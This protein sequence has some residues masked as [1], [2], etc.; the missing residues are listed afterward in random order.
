MG[1]PWIDGCS[2]K[3]CSATLVDHVIS[4]KLPRYRSRIL[5][6]LHKSL[7][8]PDTNLRDK[9]ARKLKTR[10]YKRS[11][12]NSGGTVHTGCRSR[13]RPSRC[14]D[15]APLWWS[16][17]R[18][19]WDSLSMPDLEPSYPSENAIYAWSIDQKNW[20]DIRKK[21]RFPHLEKTI[22]RLPVKKRLCSLR[23]SYSKLNKIQVWIQFYR[24]FSCNCRSAPATRSASTMSALALSTAWCKGVCCLYNREVSKYTEMDNASSR[25]AHH[26]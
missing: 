9:A 19:R 25:T 21:Q 4:S 17:R 1:P 2:L 8:I 12:R 18:S 6:R 23:G 7:D 20:F 14:W 16:Y 3:P 24:T 5:S 13:S 15:R 10:H 22:S 26:Q 11:D